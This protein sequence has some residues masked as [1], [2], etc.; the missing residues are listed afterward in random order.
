MNA[1]RSISMAMAT[2]GRGLGF[3]ISPAGPRGQ[4]LSLAPRQKTPDRTRDRMKSLAAALTLV[5]LLLAPSPAC[6]QDATEALQVP[7]RSVLPM[8]DSF[9]GREGEPPVFR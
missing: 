9:A 8:A 4:L 7:L 6:G 1:L 5:P 3:S 2:S